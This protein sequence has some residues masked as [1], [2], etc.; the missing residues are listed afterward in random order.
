MTNGT[1]N[2]IASDMKNTE[3]DTGVIGQVVLTPGL[4]FLSEMIG[5]NHMI[6][7]RGIETNK[8]SAHT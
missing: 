1:K 2:N 3:I 6:A 8:V 4:F 7:L 5:L